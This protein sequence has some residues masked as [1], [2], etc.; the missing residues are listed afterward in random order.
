MNIL[1][2]TYFAD[3][4]RQLTTDAG[5]LL[6]EIGSV[7]LSRQSFTFYTSIAVISSSRIE[8]ER[9]EADSYIKHK[10]QDIEYQPDLVEKP[11]DLYNAYVFA[12]QNKLTLQNFLHSHKLLAAHLLP[13]KW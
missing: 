2:D 5:S 1:T 12:Q 8:G 4:K 6:K 9:M 3:Y 11:D 10:M 7:E 13:E